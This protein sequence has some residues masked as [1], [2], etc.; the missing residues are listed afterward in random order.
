MLALPVPI[1]RETRAD[2]CASGIV[3][4]RLARCPEGYVEHTLRPSSL[5]ASSCRGSLPQAVEKGP[6][7]FQSL[8]SRFE[9]TAPTLCAEV[10]ARWPMG[11]PRII[12]L[13][14]F[15]DAAS[16]GAE[17]SCSGPYSSSPFPWRTCELRRPT[18]WPPHDRVARRGRKLG[19]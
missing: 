1:Q 4:R 18:R 6:A 12:L 16:Y 10:L 19:A 14:G 7:G 11:G 13:S 8:V 3:E 5:S 2:S 17:V 15:A 9:W